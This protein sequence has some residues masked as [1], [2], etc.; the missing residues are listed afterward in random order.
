MKDTVIIQGS[1]RSKGDSFQVSLFCKNE[2][3]I[4]FIDL[5][6]FQIFP[7]KY[8]DKGQDDDFI[9]LMEDVISSYNNV[10]LLTPIY[11]YS[12]SGIMKNYLDRFTDLLKGYKELGRQLRGMKMG[13]I[14]VSNDETIDYDFANPFKL[15]AEYLGMEYLGH[16]HVN[17]QKGGITEMSKKKLKSL[18]TF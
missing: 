9:S 4:P 12:M 7:Y 3:L 6:D 13:V 11:W 5:L 10:I 8:E 15:S 17:I 16:E 18:L 2:Y 14:S 1:S